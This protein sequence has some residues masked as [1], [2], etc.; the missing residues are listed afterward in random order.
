[1]VRAHRLLALL[2]A[3]AACSSAESLSP[4]PIPFDV[5]GFSVSLHQERL[6]I[7][8][9]DGRV[10]LDGLTPGTIAGDDDP[11]LVGFAVRDVTTTFEMEFGSFKPTLT[12]HGP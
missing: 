5:T 9:T 2:P 7:A 1:M 3:L 8:S 6:V 4:A 10:L 12:P 11:P